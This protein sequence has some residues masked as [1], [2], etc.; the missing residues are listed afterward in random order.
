M[1]VSGSFCRYVTNSRVLKSNSIFF[2][3]FLG[4]I[5]HVKVSP[6]HCSFYF[7]PTSHLKPSA[8]CSKTAPTFLRVLS[9]GPASVV[10]LLWMVTP[11]APAPSNLRICNSV[12]GKEC[13]TPKPSFRKCSKSA[14][15]VSLGCYKIDNRRKISKY[16]VCHSL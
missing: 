12:K 10:K 3:Y 11:L 4:V 6:L 7:H 1:L 2:P 5:A 8:Q 14:S 15:R 9:L 16:R 13:Q